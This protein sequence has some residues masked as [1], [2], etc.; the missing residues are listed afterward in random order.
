MRSR[1]STIT[2]PVILALIGTGF[3]LPL[4]AQYDL[5]T[6]TAHPGAIGAARLHP[7]KMDLGARLFQIGL[8]SA[9]V[10]SGFNFA[11]QEQ[12]FNTLDA[13]L[14]ED[15]RIGHTET[16]IGRLKSRNFI[17]AGAT[18]NALS[19][20]MKPEETDFTFSI[21]YGARAGAVMG[22]SEELARFLA[23]G[24]EQYLDQTI[25]LAEGFALGGIA[26]RELGFGAA[27]PVATLGDLRLRIGAQLKLLE[28]IT[29]VVLEPEYAE[30]TSSIEAT[31][32]RYSFELH[33]VGVND[34]D[35]DLE[36]FATNG[37]GFSA[38][39]GLA[40]EIG[41]QFSFS[42]SALNMGSITFNQS[43]TRYENSDDYLFEG[44]EV[45]SIVDFSDF[46]L[47]TLTDRFET[48]ETSGVEYRTGPGMMLAFEG[49]YRIQALDKNKY[50]YDKHALTLYYLQG[51]AHSGLVTA[52]PLIGA[53]YRY[54]LRNH[55]IASGQM[56]FGGVY[57]FTFGALAGY[58]GHW[59]TVSA[60]TNHLQTVLTGN[61]GRGFDLV[62]NLMAHIGTSDDRKRQMSKG[63]PYASKQDRAR[64]RKDRARERREKRERKREE[65]R[66]RRNEEAP[67]RDAR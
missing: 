17:G 38:D 23:L 18:I 50:L 61:G 52:R 3:L 7:A 49:G 27:G 51:L 44:V 48:E 64:A 37:A 62:F 53:G 46:S 32:Y 5:L 25:D 56:A 26:Y 28:G 67:E 19:A 31:R 29:A 13:S 9:H 54:S 41:E 8:P 58:H 66:L 21:S 43:T 24:N 60:G 35:P 6:P 10:Y 45:E 12:L 1:I 33:A 47:D 59:I 22:F 36:P 42:A 20:A 55:L 4:R 40:L 14:P 30:L 34:G 11:N 16:L 63:R 65:S 2:V 15:V 57:G 39:A